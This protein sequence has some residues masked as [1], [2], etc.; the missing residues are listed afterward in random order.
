[1]ECMLAFVSPTVID[2]MIALGAELAIIGSKQSTTDIPAHSYL[3]GQQCEDGR[4][5]DTQTRGL[6]GTIAHPVTSVGEENILMSADE[7][8]PTESI[9][10][11]ELSHAV[12][13]LGMFGT[14]Q[15][16]AIHAAFESAIEKGIYCKGSYIASNAEEYWAESSQAWF[17][18]TVRTDVTSGLTT[19]R[20]VRKR[21]PMLAT[22]LLD[23]YGD[24]SWRY[25]QTA[26]R[27]FRKSAGRWRRIWGEI[28]RVLHINS[29]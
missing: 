22:I 9:L 16:D 25:L 12:M 7:R 4:D 8:Y 19:R 29:K 27:K 13:N 21:D 2:R 14:P 3:K 1:M 10:V 20:A 24:G 15:L 28:F 18:A 5:Y 17:H 6:G 23:V 11:H 26:P